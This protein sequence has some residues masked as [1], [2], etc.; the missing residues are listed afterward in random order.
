MN[1]L[2]LKTLIQQSHHQP[3]QV[4]VDDGRVFTVSHPDFAFVGGGAEMLILA[5]GEGHA[6]GGARMVLLP[7]SHISGIDLLGKKSQ[8]AA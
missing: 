2:E 8:A 1:E 3:F 5:E 6:L 4:R 7:F